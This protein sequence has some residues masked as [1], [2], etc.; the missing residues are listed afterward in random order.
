MSIKTLRQI[1]LG[2]ET[3]SGT[4]VDA[5]WQVRAEGT[6]KD[7]HE[8]VWPAEDIGYMQQSGRSFIA[9]EGASITIDETPATS[10]LLAYLLSMCITKDED[11]T[12]DGGGGG[13]IYTFAMGSTAAR[14]APS[15]C[16]FEVGDDQRADEV[17]YAFVENMEL[18]WAAGEPLNV[19]ATL[20]GRQ[21]TDA[22]FTAVTPTAQHELTKAKLYLD[23][24]GGTIGSTQKTST[25]LGCT[26]SIP[27]GW[28]PVYTGDGQLY[29]TFLKDVGHS[30]DPI[31]GTLVLEHDAT[32]EAE[33]GFAKAGTTRLMKVIFE[34]DATTSGTD[35]TCHTFIAQAAIQYTDV[36]ELS[37]QD[38]NDTLE[39]PFKLIYSAADAQAGSFIVV[40]NLATL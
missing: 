24:T 16:T 4:A 12:A 26:L 3:T 18:S 6:L 38:G 20:R 8:R 30:T 40:N 1:Q 15:T 28:M 25:F 34:G 2:I 19:S 10:E 37:E 22:E 39:L 35:Y 32:G 17:E 23:A 31:T 14:A 21:A 9:K 36:P 5:D 27:S 29:F 33:I 7:E 11:G 13:K